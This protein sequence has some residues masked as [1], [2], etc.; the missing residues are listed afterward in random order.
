MK[1]GSKF[2]RENVKRK[3]NQA[4]KTITENSKRFLL[5]HK[6]ILV[7]LGIVSISIISGM[8]LL[9]SNQTVKQE[10]YSINELTDVKDKYTSVINGINQI[11]LFQYDLLIDGY[12]ETKANR[13]GNEIEKINNQVLEIDEFMKSDS[14]LEAYYSHL[15]DGLEQ[16]NYVY[17]NLL[18]EPF[19]GERANRIRVEAGQRITRALQTVEAA[20]SR[21]QPYFDRHFD[22][23][24]TVLNDTLN[25]SKQTLLAAIIITTLVSFSIVFIFARNLNKGIA[26]ISRRIEA[27]R[28]GDFTY[29]ATMKRKDE[30]GEIDAGLATMADQ[31]AN[32]LKANI[33]S[34]KEML[35]VSIDVG[36]HTQLNQKASNQIEQLAN[37]FKTDARQQLDYATSIS[38]VTEQASVS[39]Q[40]IEQAANSI[41]RKMEEMNREANGGTTYMIEMSES[42]TKAVAE[43][44]ELSRNITEIVSSMDEITNF[45][46]EI[47][48][49]T[50]Q[51]NLLALNASIE[52]ARAGT[53][54]KG[55]SVVANEIRNLSNQ[56]NDFADQI[57]KI[58]ENTQ[59]N[60][61]HFMK[62]FESFKNVVQTVVSTSDDVVH[63]FKEISSKNS[64]LTNENI[65]IAE[66]IQD[67]SAGLQEVASSTEELVESA[68]K[69]VGSSV[70]IT[71]FT[72]EQSKISSELVTN[73]KRLERVADKVKESTGNIKIK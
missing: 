26:A 60:T 67:I 58:I 4:K 43:T 45:M 39:S 34:S 46:G 11:G 65:E 55:F 50:G 47:E 37:V 62:Q 72:T 25:E 38:A 21:I 35:E 20:H 61:L 7:V 30:I 41:S 9:S 40:E 22:E 5:V 52:A 15:S 16:F 14:E 31:L 19:V 70:E 10:V 2:K 63:I 18:S 23:N 59:G 49:I 56:T 24:V 66:A 36:N 6:L 48:T 32:A 8:L 13:L 57:K 54:G 51:T 3:K 64:D 33:E 17:E 12:S 71:N 1:V 68:S 27:Y 42:I 44:N 28:K 29:E 73:M 69:L 53:A